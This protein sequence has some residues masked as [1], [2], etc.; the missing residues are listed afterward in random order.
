MKN[1]IQEITKAKWSILFMFML[2]RRAMFAF[3]ESTLKLLCSNN[4]NLNNIIQTH[5]FDIAYSILEIVL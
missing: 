2:I 4:N 3:C 5:T 1:I